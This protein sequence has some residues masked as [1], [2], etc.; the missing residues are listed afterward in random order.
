[1][2]GRKGHV[3]SIVNPVG[4]IDEGHPRRVTALTW[5]SSTSFRVEAGRS[6]LARLRHHDRPE[7]G[8]AGS[9]QSLERL[10]VASSAETRY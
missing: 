7:E 2:P 1:M 10:R 5:L 6:L 9:K 3:T 8:V 4:E